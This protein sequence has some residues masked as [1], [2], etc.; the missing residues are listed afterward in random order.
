M[1]LNVISSNIRFENPNDGYHNWPNRK[2]TLIKALLRYSPFIIGTQEGRREQ[3]LEL[4]S[5][6]PSFAIIDSHREWIEKRM[7]PSLYYRADIFDILSSGDI[8]LSKTPHI[9]GSSSFDSAFPRL[10]T[11]AQLKIKSTN[12]T[13][14]I[15]NVHLDHVQ[16]ETRIQQSQVMAQELLKIY[17]QHNALLIMGD[18]NCSPDSPVRNNLMSTFEHLYDPWTTLKKKETTSY[19]K[20]KG[21]LPEGS[22]IDW[23]LSDNRMKCHR[24]NFDKSYEIINGKEIYPSDHFPLI[25][26]FELTSSSDGKS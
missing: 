12:Q 22:R 18:F 11:W 24:I 10:V 21:N 16:E 23:I 3:L 4:E 2:Q 19:H 6:L 7:Y 20:F 1:L 13:L 8:W 15:S 25:G 5:D 17:Q 9:A 14:F 26:E